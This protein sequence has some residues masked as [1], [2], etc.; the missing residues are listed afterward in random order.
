[1]TI[2]KL[3]S[4]KLN[5]IIDIYSFKAHHVNLFFYIY[6]IIYLKFWYQC[7]CPYRAYRLFSQIPKTLLW[8]THSVVSQSNTSS[9]YT[10]HQ[11]IRCKTFGFFKNLL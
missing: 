4:K 7:F 10:V 5:K 1:M 9:F 3:L 2:Y 11:K 6:I 8:S